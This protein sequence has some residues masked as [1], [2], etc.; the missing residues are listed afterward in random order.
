MLAHILNLG[1][2]CIMTTT[3]DTTGS[4]IVSLPSPHLFFLPIL[5][6]SDDHIVS[7][8]P[9]PGLQRKNP[10]LIIMSKCNYN[11]TGLVNTLSCKWSL[12]TNWSRLCEFILCFTIN[13]L[14]VW[15]SR[16]SPWLRYFVCLQPFHYKLG[17]H[18]KALKVG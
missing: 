3:K 12:P 10:R 8:L 6:I 17:H 1:I 13:L 2:M 5:M 11:N 9:P 18:A 4:S 14:Q 7:P 16:Y 15:S